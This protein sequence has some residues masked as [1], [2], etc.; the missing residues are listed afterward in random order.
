[1]G[2]NTAFSNIDIETQTPFIVLV[3]QLREN[4]ERM[5]VYNPADKPKESLTKQYQQIKWYIEKS[6]LHI[7][8][9]LNA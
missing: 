8:D 9:Y 4:Y 1:M 3:E 7:G 5:A 2:F 6:T